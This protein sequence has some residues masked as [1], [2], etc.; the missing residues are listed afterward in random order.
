MK[1]AAILVLVLMITIQ[2]IA[3][4]ATG[5]KADT[6]IGSFK[7]SK[8]D[9]WRNVYIIDVLDQKNN[10]TYEVLSL[11]NKIQIFNKLKVGDEV[12]LKLTPFLKGNIDKIS[13]EIWGSLLG[14]IYVI[15][16]GWCIQEQYITKNINGL[17]YKE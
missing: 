8:I 17:R 2:L 11:K 10:C 3:Q 12:Q 4:T 9:K 13:L 5:D 6:I 15:P 16:K 1:K 7:V 14:S